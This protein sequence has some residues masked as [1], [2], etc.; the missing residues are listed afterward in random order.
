MATPTVKTRFCPSPTG[1]IHLGN[2]RTALFSALF[3][4]KN[5]GIF[6]LRIEDTDVERSKQEYTEALMEDLI[7][8]GL[9][10]QEGPFYQSKRGEIYDKYYAELEKE[11]L[12]YPCFC[13]EA[14][15][16]IMRKI[17]RSQRKPPRYARTCRHLTPEEVQAKLDEGLTPTL[18]FKVPDGEEIV[19]DDLVKGPQSFK[20]DDIGDFIIRRANGTSPFMFCNAIDD[21]LMGVTHVLRGED[22]VTNT[23]RQLMIIRAL[24]LPEINYGHISLIVAPDGSPLSKRHGSKSAV[25]L[26]EEGY[27]PLAVVNYLA[28]LGHYYGHDEMQSIEHLAEQFEMSALSSSPARFDPNQLLRWQKEG[29]TK[30]SDKGF[31]SWVGDEIL[32]DVPHH[33][34][35][36][37]IST[38]K[39]N[40]TFPKDVKGWVDTIFSDTVTYDEEAMVVLKAAGKAY[41][42]LALNTLNQRGA[43]VKAIT[44]AI[45]TELG[46]KGKALF[47]PLRVALT[48]QPHGPEMHDLVAL[49]GVD[50]VRARLSR[51]SHSL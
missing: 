40:V 42:E 30:L 25:E 20:T 47:Q 8:L 23:P 27:L 7:W 38:V 32:S 48:G 12:A 26:R 15:L 24:G 51:V 33:H 21:A 19:Y 3:A 14:D 45:K 29:V 9:P 22:H 1:L 35:G 50:G 44:M 31:L 46:V 28:R 39:P 16:E 37:F 41:F 10:W 36:L 17:Q 2:I 13:S 5:K 4:R 6:L 18:R 34:R 43:D 11:G 49:L